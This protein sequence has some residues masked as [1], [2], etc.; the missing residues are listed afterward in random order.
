MLPFWLAADLGPVLLANIVVDFDGRH[1]SY[2]KGELS[3]LNLAFAI[4]VHKSQGSEYP[5][6]VIPLHTQH[7]LLLQR[8]LLYTAISRARK[9]AVIVGSQRALGLAVRSE[10]IRTR[11]TALAERIRAAMR[12]RK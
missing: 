6:V 10:V 12:E 3:Q 7:Y 9:L 4:S 11:N 8:T 1:V 5:A 2:R